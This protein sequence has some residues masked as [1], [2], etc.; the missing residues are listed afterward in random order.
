MVTLNLG[1]RTHLAVFECVQG[2]IVCPV[3]TLRHME[4]FDDPKHRQQVLTSRQYVVDLLEGLIN[5]M[6]HQAHE[7]DGGS[8][9]SRSLIMNRGPIDRSEDEA[10][11]VRMSAGLLLLACKRLEESL[12]DDKE[13]WSISKYVREQAQTILMHQTEHLKFVT[14]YLPD[15]DGRGLQ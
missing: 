10:Y 8:G 14:N 12:D 13:F 5:N 3:S 9:V 7:I 6:I 15:P 4:F 11:V 2:A 1:F